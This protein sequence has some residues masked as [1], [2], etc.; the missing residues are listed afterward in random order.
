MTRTKL[1]REQ[2]ARLRSKSSTGSQVEFGRM[3]ALFDRANIISEGDS[4]FG[5]PKKVGSG[6]PANIIDHIAR[7]TRG[8]VNLLRLESN[9]DEATEIL[10][11]NQRHTLTKLL[12]QY[13][14]GDRPIDVLLFSAGGNDI[15]G[16][17]D[18]ERFLNPYQARFSAENCINRASFDNKIKQI[19]LA[20]RELLDIRDQYSPTTMVISHCYDIPYVTGKGAKYLGIKVSGP[21]LQPAMIER[22]IPEPMRRAV[23]AILFRDLAKMLLALQKSVGP[24]G[25]FLVADTVGTL[26]D[27]GEWLNE[28]HPKSEGFGL[29]A[30]KVYRELKT[31]LPHLPDWG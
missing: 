25:R 23:F 14:T 27:K 10:S 15:V 21:W 24:K 30:A 17:W 12:K 9:G 31:V 29:V 6:K 2:I 20:Y 11:G 3:V 8:H 13:G 7:K 22:G 18:L 4:W 16:K 5:Y 19:E 28:I 1:S 26:K